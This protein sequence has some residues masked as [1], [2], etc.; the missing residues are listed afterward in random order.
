MNYDLTAVMINRNELVFGISLKSI[1]PIV[2]EVIVVDASSGHFAEDVRNLCNDFKNVILIQTTPDITKQYKLGVEAVK[3]K[4]IL[5]WDS[6][7]EAL[8]DAYKIHNIIKDYNDGKYYVF[9]LCVRNASDNSLH[10]E[11]Y[12][13]RNHPCLTKWR[14]IKSYN[15]L[16]SLIKGIMPVREPVRPFPFWYN[17]LFLNYVI[18]LHH[19]NLKTKERIEER[20]FQ[21]P[22]ALLPDN[23]KE[24]ITFEEYVKRDG[25][26]NIG[27]S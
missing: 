23:E 7:F 1:L 3:T 9:K 24:G 15:K 22:W 17:R 26:R 20:R 11:K 18:A 2:D 16:I 5:Q 14:L 27:G 8:E 4:W 10:C 19:N 6:D 12:L 21:D 25:A 13:Y